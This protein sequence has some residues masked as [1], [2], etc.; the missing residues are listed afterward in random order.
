[1]V[2]DPDKPAEAVKREVALGITDGAT[3]QVTDGLK[4]GDTVLT[5][6]PG[7]DVQRTGTPNTCEPDNSVCYDENGKEIL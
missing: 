5:F 6:V 7:K 3:I 4:E 2:T 1:M